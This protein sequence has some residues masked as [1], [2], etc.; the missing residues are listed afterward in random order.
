M[1]AATTQVK[2][3][4][5]QIA[6]GQVLSGAGELGKGMGN[7]IVAGTKATGRGIVRVGQVTGHGIQRAWNTTFDAVIDAGDATVNFVKGM[8]A[9]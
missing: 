5:S 3:G 7:T 6:G 2:T 1:S 9:F 4:A 8:F